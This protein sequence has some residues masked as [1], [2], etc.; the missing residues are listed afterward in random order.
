MANK[1]LKYKKITQAQKL[2]IADYYINGWTDDEGN[3]QSPTISQLAEKYE[4]SEHTLYK[5][6]KQ[7]D[8]KAKQQEQIVKYQQEISKKKREK[9]SLEGVAID[10]RIINVSKQLLDKVVT[11]IH[12]KETLSPY[13]ID[14]LASASLKIQKM[15][16]LALGESTENINIDTN[17]DTDETFREAIRLLDTVRADRIQS[18]SLSNYN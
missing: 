10:D 13:Q 18:E 16:K 1:G 6:A 5:M 8:W 12:N 2:E 3:L 7:G 15:A 4:M 17:T 14:S 11:N 9:L